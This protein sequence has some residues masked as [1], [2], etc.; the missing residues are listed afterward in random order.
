MRVAT[1][2]LVHK[3]EARSFY[4]LLNAD[5][6]ETTAVF[7]VDMMQNQPLPKLPIG[8][9]FYAR[10]LWQFILGIVRHFRQNPPQPSEN[11]Y[12]SSETERFYEGEPPS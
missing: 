9:T 6:D 8:E 4:R 11:C 1:E 5:I 12:S 7:A 3:R 10:Q 2:L